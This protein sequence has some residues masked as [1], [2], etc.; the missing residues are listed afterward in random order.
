[1]IYA[2][3]LNKYDYAMPFFS[4]IIPTHKRSILLSRALASIRQQKIVLPFE[5]IVVSDTTDHETDLVCRELLSSRDVYIRRSGLPGPSES[6][7]IGKKLA[8]GN[9]LLFLDDD[10]AWHPNFLSQLIDNSYIQ[11]GK[12]IYFNC[13]VVQESR[14]IDGPVTLSEAALDLSERLTQDVYVKNQVHMSCFAWPRTLLDGINFDTHMRAYE[15]WDFQLAAYTRQ[16]PQH[17][18]ILGSRIF[19]VSDETTDRRGQS[20]DAQN[21]NAVLDYLYV[22]RRWPAPSDTLKRKRAGLLEHA[23]L[24]I[25][26]DLL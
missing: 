23:G 5:V 18:P 14:L 10:D 15:D 4:V 25:N 1:M 21:F 8:K 19:E 2:K 16:W 12:L 3:E 13:T 7:N 17:I 6:R 20:Q 24:K 9:Y 11:Q 22:Y 26:M